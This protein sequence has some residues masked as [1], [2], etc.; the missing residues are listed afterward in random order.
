[1][2]GCEHCGEPLV[3]RA[4]ERPNAFAKRRFCSHRCNNKSK[5]RYHKPKQCKLCGTE[6]QCKRPSDLAARKYCSQKCASRDRYGDQQIVEPR[7]CAHCGC[8]IPRG[9]MTPKHYQRRKTCSLSCAAK[10]CGAQ[11]AKEVVEK[12]RPPIAEVIA[13]AKGTC[14]KWA[15]APMATH[16]EVVLTPRGIELIGEA[17]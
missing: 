13:E 2:K 14:A 6:I 8:E 3:Q 11:K 15:M 7:Y 12:P 16:A 4:N 17:R 10:L 1:M 5:S 9:T